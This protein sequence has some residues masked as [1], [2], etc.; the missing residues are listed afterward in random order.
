M[1]AAAISG[2]MPG[3]TRVEHVGRRL[4]REQPLAEA[5]DGEV[6]DRRERGAVVGVEDQ[7]GDLVLLVRDE[8]L[9]EEPRQRHVGERRLRRD[10]L[11][12]VGR[13]DAGELVAG[14]EGGRLGEQVAKVGERVIGVAVGGD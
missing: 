3:A 14:A 11:A 6:A 9:F 10:A 4:V 13:G 5:A 2:V 12:R 1:T 7:A 8:R